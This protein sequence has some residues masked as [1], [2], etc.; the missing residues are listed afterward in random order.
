MDPKVLENAIEN[1]SIYWVSC[2]INLFENPEF[3][4]RTKGALQSLQLRKAL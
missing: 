1:K 2:I 3:W 4:F